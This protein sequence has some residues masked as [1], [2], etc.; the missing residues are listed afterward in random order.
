MSIEALTSAVATKVAIDAIYY[1]TRLIRHRE[2]LRRPS[3]DR[4][5]M[6]RLL[7]DGLENEPSS[8]AEALA[9]KLVKEI[10]SEANTSFEKLSS[11][12]ASEVIGQLEQLATA[13]YTGGSAIDAK[14]GEALLKELRGSSNL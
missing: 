13:R 7:V 10:E 12:T 2:R 4:G 11:A 14:R 3:A 6:P 1:V 9:Q 8:E 5:F